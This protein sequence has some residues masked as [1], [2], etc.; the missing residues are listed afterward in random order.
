M[1]IKLISAGKPYSSGAGRTAHNKLELSFRGTDNKV[2]PRVLVDF[3]FPEVF[4][5]FANT[6][7]SDDFLEVTSKKNEK[8]FWDWVAVEPSVEKVLKENTGPKIWESDSRQRSIVRQSSL[9]NAINTL[10]NEKK[11]LSPEEVIELAVAYEIWVNRKEDP[12]QA[13]KDMEDDIPV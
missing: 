10:R 1:L 4:D 2:R 12:V 6:A 5:F 7:K 9:S 8:G 3:V 11:S 13:L